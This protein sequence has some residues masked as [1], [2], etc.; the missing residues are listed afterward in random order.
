MVGTVPAGKTSDGNI[1]NAVRVLA[2]RVEYPLEREALC[3]TEPSVTLIVIALPVPAC[4]QVSLIDNAR[5]DDPGFVQQSA[6]ARPVA[7]LGRDGY[8]TARTEIQKD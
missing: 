4:A 5:R 6:L 8:G 2:D 3:G 1:G 7:N